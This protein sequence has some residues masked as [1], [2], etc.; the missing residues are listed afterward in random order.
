MPKITNPIYLSPETVNI[1]PAQKTIELLRGGF[2]V[3]ELSDDGVT[4]QTLYSYLKML[5]KMDET[6]IKFPF[7]IESITQE[8]FEIIKGWR[9][10][11]LSTK[12][13]I[14]DGGWVYKSEFGTIHE[15]WVCVNTLG[16]F[17][18][19]LND[20]GYYQQ[21]DGL[22]AQ[23]FAFNGPINQAIQIF[24]DGA[25]GFVNYRNYLK[26]FLRE[27]GKIYSYYDLVQGQGVDRIDY[28]KYIMPL[29]NSIDFKINADDLTI[30]TN[31]L[32]QTITLK[33]YNVVYKGSWSTA[34]AYVVNDV[35]ENNG[36][37]YRCISN[38]SS[39]VFASNSDKWI[40]YEGER[41]I[42]NEYH[43]FNLI[44]DGDGRGLE[45]IYTKIQ[46]LLRKSTF[47]DIDNTI[48]G[49]TYPSILQFLGDSL[50]TAK[51][52]FVD[53]I[54]SVDVNRITFTSIN[55]QTVTYPFLSGL[56]IIFSQNILDD[57]AEATIPPRYELY[58]LSTPGGSYG[59]TNAITVNDADG[60]PIKGTLNTSMSTS[61]YVTHTFD[62][63]SN[64]QGGRTPNEDAVVVLV[65]CG[66]KR[67]QFSAQTFTIFKQDSN[68]FQ[69]QNQSELNYTK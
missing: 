35:V 61:G 7:P 32:Y 48:I 53:N 29:A 59:T 15:E 12:H 45:T 65:T 68:V 5:W 8:K 69:V 18:D 58:F 54:S 49:N 28:K 36:R 10:L 33:K 41:L 51:G 64:N 56:Q 38:H 66:T 22:P 19:P 63:N 37:Y 42:G 43:A 30:Q 24:G 55:N 2:G 31:P 14:R 21:G 60:V 13:L 20:L 6:L 40:S 67:A 26:V 17:I 62:Y 52:V 1:D 16:D 57:F 9:F 47:I 50:L 11:D 34:Y 3:Y 25:H 44:I 39:T 4:L 23:N 46:Y 27:Q